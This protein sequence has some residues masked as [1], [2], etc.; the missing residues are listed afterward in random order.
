M[1]CSTYLPHPA[2]PTHP[3]DDTRYPLFLRAVAIALIDS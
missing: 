2:F 3:T 1:L